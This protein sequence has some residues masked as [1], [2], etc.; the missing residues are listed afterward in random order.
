MIAIRGAITVLEDTE[1]EIRENSLKL[2]D[3]IIKTNNLDKD[4]IISLLITATKDIKAAYP[5]KF[6]R[7]E[8]N[9]TKS[10]ILHFQEMEVENSLR[11]CIRFLINY[12]DDIDYKN[13]YL[14]KAKNLR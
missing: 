12:K 3:E 9:L 11:F 7:L 10:A 8:R 6:I 2:F 14:K 1:K 5:G 4:K 13:I